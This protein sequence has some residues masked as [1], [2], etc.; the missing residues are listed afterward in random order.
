VKIGD[1]IMDVI[2]GF[3]GVVTGLTDDRVIYQCREWGEV[4]RHRDLVTVLS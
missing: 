4:S 1:K 2:N 3:I